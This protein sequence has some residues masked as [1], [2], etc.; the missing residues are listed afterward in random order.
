MTKK[1][2][3]SALLLIFTF[4]IISGSEFLHNHNDA[5]S[6]ENHCPIC[7]ILHS[8][9]N[10][11]VHLDSSLNNKLTFD[12]ITFLYEQYKP[13]VEHSLVLSDRAPPPNS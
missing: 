9:S 6:D 4:L 2:R 1:Y 3:F 7:I 11:D 5:N 12:Y 8:L 13:F 10:I